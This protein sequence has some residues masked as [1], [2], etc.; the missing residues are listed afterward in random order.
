[1][2][3]QPK[4]VEPAMTTDE[5]KRQETALADNTKPSVFKLRGQMLSQG[6]TDA[7][8]AATDN[9]T[10]RLKV[11]ASGG[12]NELHAHPTED[13][14]FIILQGSARFYGPDGEIMELGPNEG[15][16]MPCGNLYKFNATSEEP[17]VLLRVGG[18]NTRKQTAP[19]RINVNG[20]EMRGD[21]RENKK[22]EVIFKDGEFFG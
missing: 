2:L 19:H 9:L 22:V 13:H 4:L 3:D 15:I 20:D 6:R 21:S 7:M 1:M 10:L 16:M 18:P 5:L 14:A 11:Y 8:L 17:L 12:E